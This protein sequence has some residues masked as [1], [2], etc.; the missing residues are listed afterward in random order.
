[1]RTSM[2]VCIN[3]G[4][5]ILLYGIAASKVWVHGINDETAIFASLGFIFAQ[6]AI[7]EK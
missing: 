1:M 3:V 4:F 2:L 6:L 5:S 7:G